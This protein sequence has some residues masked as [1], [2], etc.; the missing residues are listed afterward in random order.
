MTVKLLRDVL[1][2]KGPL[3]K[4]FEGHVPANLWRTLCVENNDASLDMPAQ[5]YVLSNGRP[6]PANI[7]ITLKN[8]VKWLSIN[9]RPT[10]VSPFINAGRTPS[11]EAGYY[12]LPKGSVIP[13]GLA[14]V[15]D[16]GSSH[17]ASPQY[18]IAPAFDMSLEQFRIILRSLEQHAVLEQHVVEALDANAESEDKAPDTSL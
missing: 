12:K 13:A 6:R 11:K 5:G 7:E 10:T 15:E 8:G 1:I 18:S 4:Y 14:I 3:E 17:L 9:D 16:Q 2:S